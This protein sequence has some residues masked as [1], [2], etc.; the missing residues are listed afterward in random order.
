MKIICPECNIEIPQDQINIANDL[1]YCPECGEAFSISEQLDEPEIELSPKVLENPPKGAWYQKNYNGF[2][3]GATTRS[4][5]TAV[6]MVPFMCVWSGF[7]IAGIYGSQIAKG[8]F[9]LHQ[10][11]FGLPFLIGTFVLLGVTMMA[12]W[13]K[14]EITVNGSDAN[15]LIGV[16]NKGWKRKFTWKE[17]NN[18]YEDTS[19][20]RINDQYRQVIVLEGLKKIKFGTNLTDDRRYFILDSLK[21]LKSIEQQ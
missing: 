7:S 2:T 16:G 14:V 3:I 19:S 11:L 17:I 20:I 15:V 6:F 8:H 13:G 4:V 10:S 21:Y 5:G 12:I 18:I 1:A 9:D